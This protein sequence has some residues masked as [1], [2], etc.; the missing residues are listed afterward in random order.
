MSKIKND[1][2]INGTRAQNLDFRPQS[3]ARA[4]VSLGPRRLGGTR[5]GGAGRRPPQRTDGP[6]VVVGGGDNGAGIYVSLCEP[7]RRSPRLSESGLGPLALRV[8][9]GQAAS[10][11]IQASAAGL[12]PRGAL[13]RAKA[14]GSGLGFRV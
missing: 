4:E 12:R 11:P 13:F 2:D 5:S 6:V 9:A 14:R 3:A 7:T 10:D 8:T 1:T